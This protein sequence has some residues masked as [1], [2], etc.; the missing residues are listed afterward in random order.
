MPQTILNL[1]FFMFKHI[2]K[3]SFPLMQ[4]KMGKIDQGIYYWNWKSTGSVK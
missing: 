1:S 2:Q 3:Q 4:C